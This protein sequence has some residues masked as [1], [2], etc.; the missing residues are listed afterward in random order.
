MKEQEAVIVT[1]IK[2][3][4]GFKKGMKVW[5]LGYGIGKIS[6]INN[7]DYFRVEILFKDRAYQD[8]YPF[9]NEEDQ[10]YDA[11]KVTKGVKKIMIEFDI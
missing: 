4:L 5:V 1:L 8:F 11:S 7:D 6:E 3:E 10:I 2:N 9:D